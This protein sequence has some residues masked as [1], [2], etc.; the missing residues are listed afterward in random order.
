MRFLPEAY[1]LSPKGNQI[2]SKSQTFSLIE[3]SRNPQT[4][5][6]MKGLQCRVCQWYLEYIYAFWRDYFDL[7]FK[8]L[9]FKNHFPLLFTS[10]LILCWKCGHT[11]REFGIGSI[12]QE[13]LIIYSKKKCKGIHT[14][15]R[16]HPLLH[17]GN[18]KDVKQVCCEECGHV[19]MFI[20]LYPMWRASSA[21]NLREQE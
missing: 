19:C 13:N 7:F 18:G 5:H 2:Y 9:F 16:E 12:K 17:F 11:R 21:E 4:L 20:K 1:F 15:M 10:T 14:D 3:Q 8:I 6:C